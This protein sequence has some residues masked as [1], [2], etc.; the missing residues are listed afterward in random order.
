MKGPVE[1]IEAL[2][3]RRLVLWPVEHCQLVS[4]ALKP[5]EAIGAKVHQHDQFFRVEEGCG[6]ALLDGARTALRAGF[7]VLVPA[8]TW[9]N[10]INT[11]KVPLRLYTLRAPPAHRDGMVRRTHEDAEADPEAMP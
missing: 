8:G 9:H 7:A 6:E 5:G 11:G 3:V 1:D 2:A 10:I 4:M